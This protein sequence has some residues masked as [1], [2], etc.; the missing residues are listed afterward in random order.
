M[1]LSQTQ[2]KREKMSGRSCLWLE[3]TG[4]EKLI[5]ELGERLGLDDEM[6]A[7]LHKNFPV[8]INPYYLGLIEEVNDPIW[9]QAIPDAMELDHSDSLTTMDPLAED[10]DSPVPYLTHRYPDRVLMVVQLQCAMYC[11]FCTRRR[12]VGS[13]N[14]VTKDDWDRQIEYIAPTRKYATSSSP[15]ATLS[16]CS[17]I[18]STTF[19]RT[20]GYSAHGNHPPRFPV[21][22][23]L[24]PTV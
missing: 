16:C 18:K 14:A 17:T 12:E 23:S 9:R 1:A 15:A 4:P 22:R 6:A 5:T 7:S 13:R 8:R 19:S 10:M 11:R 20:P 21:C 3:L 2:V 24:C